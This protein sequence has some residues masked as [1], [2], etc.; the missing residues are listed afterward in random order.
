MIEQGA[1]R[2]IKWEFDASAEV[3]EWKQGAIIVSIEQK[4]FASGYYTWY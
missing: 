1:E 4:H 3:E 2:A